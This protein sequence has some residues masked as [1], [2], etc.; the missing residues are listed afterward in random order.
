MEV[1]MESPKSF[2]IAALCLVS[3]LI[4]AIALAQQA[5]DAFS[6]GDFAAGANLAVTAV[7]GPTTAYLN[8]T[9]SV[10]CTVKN[11]GDAASGAYQVGLYLSTDK[12]IDPAS[13]R[14]L[15][16][17]TIATGL[18]PGISKKTISKVSVP[19]NGLSGKYYFGAVVASSKK[20][21][22][23]Q[24]SILRYS[25]DGN[26]TVT[27]HKTGLMWQRSDDGQLRNWTDAGQYCVDLGLG[28]YVDWRVPSIEELLTIVDFSRTDPA[29]DPV[30]SCHSWFYWS[31]STVAGYADGWYVDFKWDETK[32][33][34]KG[35][36]FYTR[37]VRGESW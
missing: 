12:T 9:I 23:K 30:F 32:F 35:S 11:Q 29:I 18:K 16:N 1:V 14:L 21:S 3:G 4:A 37:C 10:T 22:T 26:D 15:G 36:I 25:A 13:D 8:E 2:L 31:G 7:S 6:T 27:D 5:E 19:I 17:V 20:A 28:G 33:W 34:N 24:V